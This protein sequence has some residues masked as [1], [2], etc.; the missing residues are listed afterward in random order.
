VQDYY[1]QPGPW[2]VVSRWPSCSC[3]AGQVNC[4]SLVRRTLDVSRHHNTCRTVKDRTCCKPK[5]GWGVV[6]FFLRSVECVAQ[7]WLIHRAHFAGYTSHQIIQ[8]CCSWLFLAEPVY[9]IGEWQQHRPRIS[10]RSSAPQ[11][12]C[13]PSVPLQQMLLP[14]TASCCWQSMPCRTG[15]P[16]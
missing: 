1:C 3:P 2:W 5:R 8:C 9:P 7:G 15:L 12:P 6:C 16:L 13:L 4:P 14:R 11:N 10:G